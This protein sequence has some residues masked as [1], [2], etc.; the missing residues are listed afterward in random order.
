MWF[1]TQGDAFV[2]LRLLLRRETKAIELCR[3]GDAIE[4]VGRA[5]GRARITTRS[6][7]HPYLFN[8]EPQSRSTV[9]A[10]C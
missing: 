9:D 8:Q 3:P 1:V 2:Q 10:C 5:A 7:A 4:I 6:G